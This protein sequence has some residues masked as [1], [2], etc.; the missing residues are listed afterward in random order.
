MFLDTRLIISS[1]MT[2][3]DPI[4]GAV[5]E[6]V[7]G[8]L[9]LDVDRR[10]LRRRD[11]LIP[12]QPQVF[13]LLVYLVLN[14]ERV[15]SKDDLLGAV[16]GGRIVSEATLTSRINAA[17]N[18]VGDSGAA[19][20]L[21]RTI[22]R[23]GF[24]FVGVV[25]EEDKQAAPTRDRSIAAEDTQSPRAVPGIEAKPAPRLS[26]LVLPF[27]NLSDDPEQE[28]FADGMVEEITTALS[29]IRWLFVIA[30]NTSFTYKGQAVDVKQ[31]GREL[32]VRYV[33][34]GSV[35]KAGGRVRI[36]ARLVDTE[37]GVHL[38]GDHFDGSLEDVF[39]L[40]DRV[41]SSVA[42]VIEPTLH[43]AEQHRSIKKPT[44][45]PTAYDLY[46]RAVPIFFRLRKTDI[47][48]AL[49]LLQQAIARDPNY[50]TALA[51]AAICYMR[52]C[53][54]D[55][56]EDPESNRC[57]ALDLARRALQTASDDPGVLAHVAYVFGFLGED[58]TAA[59]ALADRALS[60]HPSYARGWF[61]S[62]A[63]RVF[64]GHCDVAIEHLQT[65][66]RLSPRI[67]MGGHSQHIGAA[68]FF[69]R[70]FEK[71]SADLLLA[72]QEYPT[73][74]WPSRL[75]ASCLANKGLLVEARAV[76][77]RIRQM[78]PV[79]VPA[80]APYRIAEHRDLFFDGL[81]TATR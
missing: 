31:V 67:R 58:I 5:V 61:L 45:D 32:D 68:N 9:R 36:T 21:I 1:E 17:R 54:D 65:S 6:F 48:N 22:A 63:V 27:L 18:A 38:W 15:V 43:A 14:R 76:V 49:D 8:D 35:R 60:L 26:I 72:V 79:V 13:D 40:Q 37:T 47:L 71:A 2:L 29:R 19:Q 80:S 39:E 52:L 28:Y 33:L 62:G 44:R 34:E 23:K 25:R 56:S 16:W 53:V 69:M 81:E 59:V 3:P 7:F 11:Q 57:Q 50:A 24:R 78:T 64:A 42:G 74:P 51:W 4:W 41:G 12:L 73:S 77:E 66:L 20:H 46:L 30:R 55:F 70:R 10:E 75:L